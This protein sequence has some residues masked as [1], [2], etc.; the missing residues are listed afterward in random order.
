MV[1]N[2]LRFFALVEKDII[3]G[4]GN[5]EKGAR[6]IAPALGG[7]A[8]GVNPLHGGDIR[9]RPASATV[10]HVQFE[11]RNIVHCRAGRVA[12]R[13]ADNRAAVHMLPGW[14]G[15]M[16]ADC[17]VVEKQSRDRLTKYPGEL[18][19]VARFTPIDLRTHGMNR[20]DDFL[21]RCDNC[22]RDLRKCS[23]GQKYSRQNQRGQETRACHDLSLAWQVLSLGWTL[24]CF[25]ARRSRGAHCYHTYGGRAQQKWSLCPRPGM[26]ALGR[27]WLMTNQLLQ[28]TGKICVRIKFELRKL[29][30]ENILRSIQ[31]ARA[32][33]RPETTIGKVNSVNKRSVMS[34]VIVTALGLVLTKSHLAAQSAKKLVGTWT[35]ASADTFGPSPV[36]SLM[37]DGDGHF[38][39]IFMRA[40]LPRY[41]SNSRLEGTEYEYKT[42]VNGAVAVF[43][44]YSLTG[45]DLNLH[46][47]GSTFPN[48]DGTDQTRRNVSISATELKYTQPTP[49]AGGPPLVVIWKRASPLG[50]AFAAQ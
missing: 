33:T 4:I 7:A 8:V 31:F 38:S 5:A 1:A 28:N 48:W 35:L 46:I 49:S 3:R 14:T 9:E 16:A 10:R 29:R 50:A 20:R 24:F 40:N 19:I 11:P 32:T 37:F 21:A 26:S 42:T 15:V 41:A 30:Y 39:A 43:G 34:I 47:E 6:L 17:L 27:E 45:T 36:G 22:R 23:M 12:N 2:F 13:V 44:A 18:A 25:S